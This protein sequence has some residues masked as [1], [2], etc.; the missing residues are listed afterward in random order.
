M[1]R[2]TA[3]GTANNF[4]FRFLYDGDNNVLNIKG[5]NET[6]VITPLSIARDTGAATFSGTASFSS[7]A[8]FSDGLVGTPSISFAG[9]TDTG[10]WR[11]G[12]NQLW[13]VTTGVNRLKIDSSGNTEVTGALTGTTASFSGNV[14]MISTS[15][16]LN[17]AG[18]A[19]NQGES[20]RIRLTEQDMTLGAGFQG[21]FIHYDGDANKFNIGVHDAGNTA[22]GNDINAIQI[23]RSNGAVTISDALTV[24]GNLT[25]NGTTTTIDTTNLLIEDPLML[26]ARVQSGTPTLDSG[27][28]I[29]RGSSTNVGMIWDESADQF[30][31]INT[32]D[33]ATTAGNVT[34][35][36]YAPLQ[37]A[38]LTATTANITG[39]FFP[40][41][42]IYLPD[43]SISAPS[44]RW[45]NDS[46][47]G[48]YRSGADD[49]GVSVGGTSVTRFVNTGPKGSG[50]N[51]TW[52]LMTS[53]GAGSA[54]LPVYSFEGDT[55]TGMY[56]T[57]ADGM[58]FST[59]GTA[60]LTIDS[61]GDVGIGK[62]RV[63]G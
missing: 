17:I 7:T 47:T 32:T 26:L 54:A 37:T 55:N 11:P 23:A 39:P 3:F 56:W 13:F 63:T 59:G 1:E 50:T 29:E 34:I 28:I 6:S 10:I 2:G 45:N 27:F 49:L 43:G 41:G 31:F 25:V 30:A 38:A 58:G 8:L 36:S 24:T 42:T 20:G 53:S 61:S 5:C 35:A 52:K 16:T 22:Y 9:D 15:P 60:R 33:T 12:S 57:G 44:I 48:F 18:A 51:G 40:N 21:A 62:R 19:V 14:K 46:N 4:G